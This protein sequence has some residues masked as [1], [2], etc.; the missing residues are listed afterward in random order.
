VPKNSANRMW[1][2]FFALALHMSALSFTVVFLFYQ[3]LELIGREQIE[4]PLQTV[5]LAVSARIAAAALLV[6]IGMASLKYVPARKIAWAH[7]LWLLVFAWYGWFSSGSP[8]M[9]HEILGPN[10]SWY[11]QLIQQ[12]SLAARFIVLALIFSGIPLW[13]R[14]RDHIEFLADSRPRLF[15]ILRWLSI[16]LFLICFGLTPIIT[17]SFTTLGDSVYLCF[18][19]LLVIALVSAAFC[20]AARQR[21]ALAILFLEASLAPLLRLLYAGHS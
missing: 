13:I 7:I 15:G 18:G 2:S 19:L 4:M 5:V 11:A 12:V 10:T 6:Y 14:R 17:R 8:F 1:I 3:V 9:L 21:G 16:V 20:S